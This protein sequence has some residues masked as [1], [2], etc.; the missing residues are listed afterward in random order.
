[1][2]MKYIKPKNLKENKSLF[3]LKLLLIK[4]RTDQVTDEAASD[5]IPVNSWFPQIN[6]NRFVFLDIIRFPVQLIWLTIVC[7]LGTLKHKAFRR[8]KPVVV[9]KHNVLPE[10]TS[11]LQRMLHR[12]AL[13]RRDR[14]GSTRPVRKYF[15]DELGE[16]II[17]FGD[18]LTLFNTHK[19][20]VFYVVVLSILALLIIGT[21]FNMVGQSIFVLL[22]LAL[23]YMIRNSPGRM[24][25]MVMISMSLIVS[26]RYMYWRFTHSLNLDK[27]ID[28]VWGVLLLL[29]EIYAYVFLV[30]GYFQSGWLRRRKITP[31]PEDTSLWPTVDVFVPTYNEP[32]DIVQTT[33]YAALKLDWPSSKLKIYL[34]DDG[35]RDAFKAF[36]QDIGIEYLSRP[37][38]EFAKAGNL[39]YGL[40]H[41]HGDLIAVFD[42]DHVPT[43]SFLQVTV[44]G[45]LEDP[46]LFLVQTP[47]QFYSEDPFEKNLRNFRLIPNESEL[48]YS[49]VQKGNDFWNATFFCGSC[50]VLKRAPL[51]EVGG[52]ALETVT[53]DA[54]TSL[55]LH[56]LG[57]RSRYIDIPQA[58]GLS[59]E[60]LSAFIGQRMR[61][62]RGMAQ[63]FR[64]DNP[65]MGKGLSM[66]Q[67]ICYATSMLNFFSGIPRLIFLTAPL[68]FL[69][70]HAYVILAPATTVVLYVL[71]HIVHSMI[72]KTR[73]Q[74]GHR[75]NFFSE[76]YETVLSWYMA[77]PTTMA[78]IN[79]AKGKFN[80]TVKGQGIH[81]DF[82]D[83]QSATPYMIIIILNIAGIV[84]GVYRAKFGPD[85]ELFSVF[86]NMVWALYNCFMLG[87]ALFAAAEVR[88]IRVKHRIQIN[89][90]VLVHGRDG[91]CFIG[92]TQN[93]SEGGAA[94]LL[95][96]RHGIQGLDHIWVTVRCA[97]REKAFPC[98]VISSFD[99]GIRIQW[100]FE[101]EEQ[102][103][104]FI[105][106]TF[107]RANIWL[108]WT[109]HIQ[110][111]H[112]FLGLSK[113][114]TL[115]SLGYL[116][117]FQRIPGVLTLAKIS[118]KLYRFIKS[119]L[120]ITP[121]HLEYLWK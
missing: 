118:L 50:A 121:K 35:H 101:S 62:S 99:N 6:F 30:F 104:E 38:N 54:H 52:I 106:F 42:C 5:V 117:M 23:S 46:K 111:E 21:P 114:V 24:V 76:V 83:F 20:R 49:L 82:F 34:L 93:F 51:L 65:L 31:L 64:I 59:P 44:G 67:R 91:R 81:R 43:R 61:W 1:M 36:A 66:M 47:H 92:E 77:G 15:W 115:G 22:M 84:A 12:R 11:P 107:G 105:Q 72:A 109:D 103:R 120:P 68:G 37:D 19:K 4:Q 56:R 86:M 112:P 7:V 58:A 8:T 70:F 2:D 97:N 94:I 95:G 55:R 73:I 40:K 16:K 71:P 89:M 63:I 26:T 90:T 69:F 57:Y 116:R 80:V 74:D 45:F 41:S 88:Q 119:L 13:G 100:A 27:P 75:S 25:N 110:I 113:L 39:N 28:L 10:T 14:S 9:E 108:Y 87:S 3:F 102:R 29:A 98:Q 33:I 96:D 18:H 85:N 48:F 78:L 60:S 53:E 79:P 32:L 17:S